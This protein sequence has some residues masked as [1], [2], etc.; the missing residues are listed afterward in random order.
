MSLPLDPYYHNYSH[1]NLQV[2]HHS[3]PLTTYLDF[4]TNISRVS[5]F[6]YD[7][8]YFVIK[9]SLPEL[10]DFAYCSFIFVGLVSFD[11]LFLW[12]VTGL[13]IWR[14]E[15][16]TATCFTVCAC[17]LNNKCAVT[18]HQETLKEVPWTVTDYHVHK[19]L[20]NIY[21]AMKFVLRAA[22]HS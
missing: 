14:L 16:N 3:A 17:W 2:S 4:S 1:L 7:S 19:Y 12:S 9:F 15:G 8:T 13:V 22:T 21:I 10:P 20:W 6:F 18:N 5:F 11:Y